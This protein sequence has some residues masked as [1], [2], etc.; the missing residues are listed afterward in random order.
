MN[1]KKVNLWKVNIDFYKRENIFPGFSIDC[2]ILGF[3]KGKI[4]VLLREFEINDY[5]ALLGG[6]MLKSEDADQAAYR[7]LKSYTQLD[8]IFLQQFYLFSDPNR[9]VMPDNLELAFNK[10]IHE[11]SW[12]WVANRFISMGYFALIKYD[13]VSLPPKVKSRLKWFDIQNLPPL[14]A[15]HQNIIHTALK[16]IRS[17]LPILPIGYQLLPEK[18]TM[19][20]LRKI[21][22]IILNRN[23]DRRNFQRKVLSEGNIIQL[24]EKKDNRKYNPPSLFSF[25]KEN[26][27]F[28]TNEDMG[29]IL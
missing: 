27:D 25:K 7:I 13:E 6:F 19:T 8:D 23:L 18:F 12:E 9:T 1:K 29:P 26:L 11:N 3:H 2:V 17:L 16:V 20:E 28:L 10:I 22:E 4:R 15:D 5:W 14:Y 21:Y 24:D